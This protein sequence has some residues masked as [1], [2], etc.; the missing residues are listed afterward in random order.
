MPLSP[1]DRFVQ[2]LAG[3]GWTLLH[4]SPIGTG[5]NPTRVELRRGRLQ[6]RLLVY[7]WRITLEGKGRRRAGRADLD[8]RVQTTR[9]HE[10]PLLVLPG[11]VGCGIGWDEE[12]VI[13]AAFDP[14]VKRHTGASSSVHFPRALLDT[15][16][17]S[18]WE[19]LER[20]ENGPQVAFQPG[21]IDRFL[22]WAVGLQR[23]R[24]IILEPEQF[25]REDERASVVVDPWRERRASWL[26][27]GDQLV[28]EEQGK[29]L[30]MNVWEIDAIGAQ[31]RQ[32]RSGQYNR[33]ALRLLCHRY[34]IVRNSEWVEEVRAQ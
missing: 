11:F 22:S 29:L 20:P 9:S 5:P 16:A 32:T 2:A 13:F 24:L 34:G 33:T 1:H 8:Y 12:R 15:A 14:W 27:P 28:L 3:A 31:Q 26:R 10:G 25:E 18:G 30:D 4:R 17:A 7:A 23:R 19:E 6:R 21:Q